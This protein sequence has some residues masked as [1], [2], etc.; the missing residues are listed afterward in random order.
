M[1][2]NKF[3]KTSLTFGNFFDL[4]AATEIPLK[5]EFS[6]LQNA[7]DSFLNLFLLKCYFVCLLCFPRENTREKNTFMRPDRFA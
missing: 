4:S 1:E 5:L 7:Q 6:S 2:S 3:S